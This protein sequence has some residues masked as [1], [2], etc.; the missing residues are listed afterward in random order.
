MK[1]IITN[2]RYY[3]LLAVS[4]VAFLGIIATPEDNATVAEFFRLM[5]ITK[6]VGII[7]A[8]ITVGLYN[9]WDMNGDIPELSNLASEE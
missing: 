8:I 7:A 9:Y 6:G 1:K 2:Y 5:A 4:T 3:I